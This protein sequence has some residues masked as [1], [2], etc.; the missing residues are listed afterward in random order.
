MRAQLSVHAS[1]CLPLRSRANVLGP[2]VCSSPAPFSDFL[3]VKGVAS[4]MNGRVDD[5][6][7]L[8]TASGRR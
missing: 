7:P 4:C 8:K 2:A 5:P 3:P 6:L 1:A